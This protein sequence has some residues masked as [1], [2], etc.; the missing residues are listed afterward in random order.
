MEDIFLNLVVIALVAVVIGGVFIVY[1]SRQAR[2]EAQLAREAQSRGWQYQRIRERLVSGYRL[3]GV[4][5]GNVAWTLESTAQSSDGEAAPGSS[6]IV[7]RTRWW[8]E[9]ATLPNRMAL[10][11]SRPAAGPSPNVLGGL[12]GM[13]VQAALRV[14]LG[15]QAGQV[16]GLS[17]AQVGSETFRERYMVF[18]HDPTEAQRLLG[19]GVESALL[20]WPMRQQIVIK[21]SQSGIEVSILGKQI[22]EV[23]EIEQIV[24]LGS[25]LV[26]AWQSRA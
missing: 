5:S 22:T 15:D 16:A 25:R 13:V 1:Y 8:S 10:I 26:L 17:E 19:A 9:A 14:M 24:G 6:S 4:A 11:G 12:G 18:A 21:L 20:N 2:K 3:S 7:R 23:A